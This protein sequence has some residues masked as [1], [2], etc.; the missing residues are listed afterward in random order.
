MLKSSLPTFSPPLWRKVMRQNFVDI[1]KLMDF[2]QL[3]AHDR[4][5]VLKNP[6]FVLNVPMRL[7]EKIVKGSLGDPILRQFLPLINEESLADDFALDPVGDAP[8]KISNK[9]IHKYEGRVLLIVTSA[10]AMH[11]RYCFRQFFDYEVQDKSFDE[12]LKIIAGDPSIHEVIL[13]GG[14]PLSLDTSALSLLLKGIE[15]IP[16][17]KLIR[18][19]TRFPIGIPERIDD[20]F[21]GLLESIH[22]QI[23]FVIHSNHPLELDDEVLFALKKVRQLGIP[24]LNQAVLLKGINDD[25]ATQQKLH[26]RLIE[27]GIIPY[28]LHQLDKV[29]GTTHFEVSPLVG[30]TLIEELKKQLPG[31]AVPR[32]VKE[33]P[34]QPGKTEIAGV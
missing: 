5:Q 34:G 29:Q 26:E 22:K 14:D 28:Y 8:C 18:F 4:S 19:H 11:C 13:S 24:I 1:E 15:K 9:L 7:A 25:L 2:L 17:V 30:M 16:H 12:E 27:G 23:W 20:L 33:V 31:Y 6:R 21:L 3:Q 10:C 32:Y